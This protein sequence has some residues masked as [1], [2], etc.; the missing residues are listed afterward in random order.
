M[1][2]FIKRLSDYWAIILDDRCVHEAFIK[3]GLACIAGKYDKT[4][5]ACQYLPKHTMK[6]DERQS[7]ANGPSADHKG[8]MVDTLD[9]VGALSSNG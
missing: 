3:M 4:M 1:L 9:L 5:L 7:P 8:H 6:K 2:C